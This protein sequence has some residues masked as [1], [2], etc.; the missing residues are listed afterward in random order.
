MRISKP[1]ALKAKTKPTFESKINS[2]IFS[3]AIN[4]AL[5]G[6]QAHDNRPEEVSCRKAASYSWASHD[7][8]KNDTP[9][10]ARCGR[11]RCSSTTREKYDTYWNLSLGLLGGIVARS[12]R[13][14]GQE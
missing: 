3:T 11:V 6:G 13:Q 9:M 10:L 14:A 8:N 1:A 7:Y 5:Q 12:V 4:V 2:F